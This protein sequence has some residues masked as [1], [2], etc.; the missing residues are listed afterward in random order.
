MANSVVLA[1][2]FGL[3][4]R[5]P[6]IH[7]PNASRCGGGA[8]QQAVGDLVGNAEPFGAYRI[9]LPQGRD[10]VANCI[11]LV[12]IE[13]A[14]RIAVDQVRHEIVEAAMA[15]LHGLPTR[16]RRV[17]RHHRHQGEIGQQGPHALCRGGRTEL[18]EGLGKRTRPRRIGLHALVG[19]PCLLDD[20]DHCEE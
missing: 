14:A 2:T 16:L 20:I 9:G 17:C 15:A 19:A 11:D 10:L 12:G 3:P 13:P 1:V 4:S 6:P 7:E 18:R 5:S 8:Q